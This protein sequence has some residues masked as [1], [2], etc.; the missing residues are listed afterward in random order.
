MASR[1]RM[2]REVSAFRRGAGA[3]AESADPDRDEFS[4][5]SNTWTIGPAHSASGNAMLLINPHLAWGNTFYRYME[6]HLVGPGYDLYG[7]PQ[8]GFPV[9]VVGFN[10]RARWSRTVNTIDTVDFYKLTV[11]GT[12]YEF[13]GKLRDFEAASKTLKIRRPDE[14]FKEEKL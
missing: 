8:V 3:I 10:R 13:V 11:K 2:Q 9:P 5:G 7:A 4:A 14:S 1:D 12:Q 6:V